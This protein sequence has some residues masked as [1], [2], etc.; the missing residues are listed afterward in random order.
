M[1]RIPRLLL[2]S[3]VEHKG[4][5]QRPH[6]TYGHGLKRN[7]SNAGVDVKNWGSLANNHN[8]WH[9]ITQKKNIH[10]NSNG[11]GPACMDEPE[12][13]ETAAEC[14]LPLPSS[15]AGVILGLSAAS[16]PKQQYTCNVIIP[17]ANSNCDLRY[18]KAHS[19]I[20]PANPSLTII[21]SPIILTVPQ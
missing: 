3:W 11:G 6:L 17:P 10:C 1:S 13:E 8:L 5:Q 7:L 4:S 16:T 19:S 18:I 14:I 12:S 20:V 21:S 9:A 2:S 15:Y